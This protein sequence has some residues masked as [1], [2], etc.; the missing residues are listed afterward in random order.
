MPDQPGRPRSASTDLRIRGAVL[1]LLHAHGPT[2]VTVEAVAAASGV[3]KTTIYRRFADREDLL[4][5][6]LTE[7]I[8]DPG[9]APEGSTREKIRWALGLIWHQLADVLGPGGIA[10]LIETDEPYTEIIRGIVAPY[11]EAL[12]DLIL[13]DVEAG[14]LRADLDADACVSLL[15]G[16]YLGELVRRGVVA[17]S[18]TESCL[19]LMWITMRAPG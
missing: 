13:A 1:D 18:F 5:S 12:A 14:V 2:A 8:N 3:A 6:T 9:R 11:S 10:A 19:D 7:L 15:V 16:A 4:R 17:E